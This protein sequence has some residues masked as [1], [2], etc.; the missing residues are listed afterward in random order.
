[1]FDTNI[2]PCGSEKN[3]TQCCLPIIQGS[4]QAT[5][6]EEL[7]R[8]RY[9]AFTQGAIDFILASHHSRTRGEV[10]R[11]EIEDWSKNS[12]WLGLK[13][14]QSQ[15]GQATDQTGEIVFS[16]SYR[17]N[18]KTEEHWEKSFFEKEKDGWKFLD[19]HGIQVG[20]YR[21]AEPKIGRN[22]PCSCGSNKK[23]KK[24]CGSNSA[25]V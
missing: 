19:A 1:M 24:C 21:R 16:A 25:T 22:D 14:V 5:T 20:T 10:K 18:G 6:A 12:E 7:L 3:L 9:V 8:A 2:C 23:Y 17:S 11:D 15:A 4:R 13:I